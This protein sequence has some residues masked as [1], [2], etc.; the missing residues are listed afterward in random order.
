MFVNVTASAASQYMSVELNSLLVAKP[1]TDYI[2][3]ARIENLV[4]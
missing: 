4:A 2:A 1:S 3:T